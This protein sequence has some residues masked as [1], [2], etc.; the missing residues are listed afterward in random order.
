VKIGRNVGRV[1]MHDDDWNFFQSDLRT[2]MERLGVETSFVGRG[3]GPWKDDLMEESFT[4]VGG[5]PDETLRPDLVDELS[6]LAF[7]YSQEA[8]DLTIGKTVLVSAL[9]E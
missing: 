4:I 6:R 1:R 3:F 5:L 9:G 7:V 2:L 8:I